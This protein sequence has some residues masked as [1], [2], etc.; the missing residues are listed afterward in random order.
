MLNFLKE[1]FTG[2]MKSP[3]IEPLGVGLHV[4]RA[5]WKSSASTTV[6][7]TPPKLGMLMPPSSIALRDFFFGQFL[8]VWFFSPHVQHFRSEMATA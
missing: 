4:R 6:A 5:G 3:Q 7:M 8:E 1:F 2:M